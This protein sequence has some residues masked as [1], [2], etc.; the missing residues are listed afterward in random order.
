[1][2]ECTHTDTRSNI[3]RMSARNCAPSL[4]LCQIQLLP[5]LHYS[6]YKDSHFGGRY[7]AKSGRDDAV[8]LK[9][10]VTFSSREIRD[11]ILTSE[12]TSM[13]VTS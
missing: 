3:A 1:M 13:C 11:L 5:L 9:R 4:F 12:A 10:S 8:M 7:M 2:C 6:H